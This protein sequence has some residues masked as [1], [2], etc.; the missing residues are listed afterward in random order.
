MVSHSLLLSLLKS[1]H[2]VLPDVRTLH[3]YAQSPEPID[4]FFPDVPA[5][6]AGNV[7]QALGSILRTQL[8]LLVCIPNLQ[9][10]ASE[11]KRRPRPRIQWAQSAG[12]QAEL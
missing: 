9:D 2:R 5:H 10:D 7:T 12:T 3:R 6:R 4:T 11:D 1:S 8:I